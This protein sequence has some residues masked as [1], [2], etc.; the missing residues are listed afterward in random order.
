MCDGGFSQRAMLNVG[1]GS[2]GESVIINIRA[3][4]NTICGD[5]VW[6]LVFHTAMT[7][8]EAVLMASYLREL[9]AGNIGDFEKAGVGFVL[10]E[11][12][13]A[14][15]L[16]SGRGIWFDDDG[17]LGWLADELDKAAKETLDDFSGA[18]E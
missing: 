6:K 7:P 15:Y 17:K 4:Y 10:T 1:V 9:D 8:H 13:A 11:F 5:E 16:P 3:G 18:S 2:D 14:M 12:G